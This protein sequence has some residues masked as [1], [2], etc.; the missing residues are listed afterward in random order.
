MLQTAVAVFYPEQ[1][2]KWRVA[3]GGG[4]SVATLAEL[5]S[6]GELSAAAQN[7]L[8]AH[9]KE[10]VRDVTAQP[11]NTEAALLNSVQLA[12]GP[13]QSPAITR[14]CRAFRIGRCQIASQK[15]LNEIVAPA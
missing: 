3:A 2:T 15:L 10:F 13:A 1:A 7:D 4:L 11:Q 8:Y 14:H 9:D 12:L 6:G 5:Q